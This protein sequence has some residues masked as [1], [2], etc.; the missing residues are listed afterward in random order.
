MKAYTNPLFSGQRSGYV[1]TFPL[2][3]EAHR[4]AQCAMFAA[5]GTAGL[6]PKVKGE[7]E[8]EAAKVV[9]LAGINQFLG[10][11]LTSRTQLTVVEM[12]L[13]TVAIEAGVFSPGWVLAPGCAARVR[14]TITPE[15]TESATDYMTPDA[16]DPNYYAGYEEHFYSL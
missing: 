2:E 7:A 15:I 16:E 9:M 13:V 4:K 1:A 8:R 3:L 6:M 10:L 14:I 11:R 5:A 12:E